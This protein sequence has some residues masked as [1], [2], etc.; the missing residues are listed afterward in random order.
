MP[1]HSKTS[2]STNKQEGKLLKLHNEL[3][4]IIS[5][6]QSLYKVKYSND[7]GF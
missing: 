5:N 7:K 4:L 6:L 1:I 2:T 3:V